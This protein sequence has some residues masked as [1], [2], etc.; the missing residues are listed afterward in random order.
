MSLGRGEWSE[1]VYSPHGKRLRGHDVVSA[2]GDAW[3]TLL[4]SWY[5]LQVLT[6]SMQSVLKVDQ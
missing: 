3:W 1:D 2:S 4:N 5:S 6:Y